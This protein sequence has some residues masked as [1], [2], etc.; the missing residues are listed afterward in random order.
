M[1]TYTVNSTAGL[2]KAIISQVEVILGRIADK[3]KERV[4]QE[5][6]TYYSEYSPEILYGMKTFYYDRTNQLRNCCKI[7]PVVKGLNN[8]TVTVYLDI[9]SLN[10][11]TPGADAWKTVVAADAGLH[12]GWVVKHGVAIEQIPWDSLNEN[13]DF[14][15]TDGARIWHNPM[16]ELL[17]GGKLRKYFLEEAKKMRLDI[18][19]K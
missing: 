1:A 15:D 19:A 3:V 7:S 4:D 14:S 17:E 11:S 8:I 13:S 2:T 5:F 16:K 6:E 18:V 9:D 12:G 10:Y